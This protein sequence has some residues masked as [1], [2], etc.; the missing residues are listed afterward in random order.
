MQKN[1]SRPLSVERDCIVFVNGV[2]DH[3]D[4]PVLPAAY[5]QCPDQRIKVR[6]THSSYTKK[7]IR[8]YSKNWMVQFYVRLT[9]MVIQA[10]VEVGD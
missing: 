6:D 1:F 5:P 9:D 7:G 8:Y 10:V 2:S 4:G 3:V